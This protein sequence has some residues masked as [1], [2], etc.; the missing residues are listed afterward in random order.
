MRAGRAFADPGRSLLGFEPGFD[1]VLTKLQYL[2][3]PTPLIVRLLP[4]SAVIVHFPE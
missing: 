1:G 2:S 3:E 4:I